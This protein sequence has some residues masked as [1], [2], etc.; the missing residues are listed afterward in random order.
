MRAAVADSVPIV[1]GTDAGVIAH[2]TNAVEF[3]AMLRLGM[4]PLEAMRS[5]TARAARF[6]GWADRIGALAPGL[7]AD[8]IAVDGDPLTDITALSRVRF[9]MK[10]GVAIR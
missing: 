9:V 7:L 10:G 3:A 2:G 1:F 6:I 4:T 5:A 8:I